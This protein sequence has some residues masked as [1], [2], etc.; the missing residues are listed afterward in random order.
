MILGASTANTVKSMTDAQD[1]INNGTFIFCYETDRL[2]IKMHDEIIGITPAKRNIRELKC[3]NCGAPITI[4]NASIVKCDYCGSVYDI[5]NW[6]MDIKSD[7][8]E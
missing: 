2:Y 5:D 6:D 4:K 8:E 1:R 3:K 7:K